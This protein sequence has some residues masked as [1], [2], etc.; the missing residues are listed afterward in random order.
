MQ[1][2]LSLRL[3]AANGKSMGEGLVVFFGYFTIL[4]NILVALALTAAVFDLSSRLGRSRFGRFTPA[5][6]VTGGCSR[7]RASCAGARS[8]RGSPTRSAS[9]PIR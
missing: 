6:F 8:A 5:L 7:R 9:S 2:F 1:L 3:A 4:T